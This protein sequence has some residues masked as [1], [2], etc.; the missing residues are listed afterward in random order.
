MSA[1]RPPLPLAV[2]VGGVGNGCPQ[3]QRQESRTYSEI[4]AK[5]PSVGHGCNG[6][7]IRGVRRGSCPA[8]LWPHAVASWFALTSVAT[9]CPQDSPRPAAV[10]EREQEAEQGKPPS[11]GLRLDVDK[12][13]ERLLA[14]RE[15]GGMPRF[16]T[17]IEVLGKSPQVMLERFF[18]GLDLE[19]GPVPSAAP[20]DV[21]MRTFRHLP[22]PYL[23]LAALAAALAKR[24]KEKGP[25]RYFLYRVRRASG[26]TYWLREDRIPDSLFFNS[27]GTTFE[28][29]ATFPDVDSAV[30][31]F[32]R[33]ERGFE[34]PKP[35][36]SA[37][38]PPPWATIPCR[39]TKD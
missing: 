39:P 21:D 31:G 22:T 32:R 19:C 36:A 8:S 1:P 33:M 25:D 6:R 35:T 3:V 17:S 18:R 29:T 34:T 26:V 23:D 38:P 9:P 20:T 2:T 13:V 12:H 28:L 37:S 27:P 4:Q 15:K 5:P 10:Q 14:D 30:K 16:E 24:Q 7:V 11:S